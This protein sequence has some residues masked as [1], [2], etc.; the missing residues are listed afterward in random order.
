[1]LALCPLSSFGPS[2]RCSGGYSPE[3]QHEFPGFSPSAFHMGFVLD[4]MT[5]GQVCHRAFNFFVSYHSTSV[6]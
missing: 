3:T 5:V 6:P 1:V 4:K 2:R